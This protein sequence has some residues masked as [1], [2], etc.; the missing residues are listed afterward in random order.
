MPMERRQGKRDSQVPPLKNLNPSCH[1]VGFD[2]VD[3]KFDDLDFNH[4]FDTRKWKM[5]YF[6]TIASPMYAHLVLG[7]LTA[8]G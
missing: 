3:F 1:L 5:Y 4:L 6:H 8:L 2:L 7:N